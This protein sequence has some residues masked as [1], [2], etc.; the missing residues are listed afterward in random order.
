MNPTHFKEFNE[1]LTINDQYQ[2]WPVSPIYKGR[3]E[4]PSNL[5]SDDR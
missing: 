5:G 3:A 4:A 1:K 2:Y